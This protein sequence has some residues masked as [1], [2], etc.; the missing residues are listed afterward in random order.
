MAA[1]PYSVAA[2]LG[3]GRAQQTVRQEC[4]LPQAR[5]TADKLV[6]DGARS[7]RVL[8]IRTG[9]CVAWMRPDGTLRWAI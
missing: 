1:K 8:R 6:A 9:E 2:F 7:V 3:T 4:T 5:K